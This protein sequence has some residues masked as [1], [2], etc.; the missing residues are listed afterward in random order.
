MHPV[1]VGC[2]VGA[3]AGGVIVGRR[4]EQKLVAGVL[5]EFA[6][7]DQHARSLVSRCYTYLSNGVKSELK[8]LGG[9]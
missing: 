8:K 9:I 4:Y 2:V 6:K 1:A 7:V 3:F 5:S